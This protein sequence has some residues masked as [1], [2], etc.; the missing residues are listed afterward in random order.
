MGI[1]IAGDYQFSYLTPLYYSPPIM[2]LFI[3]GP[4]VM[5][6][7]LRRTSAASG[8]GVGG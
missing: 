5:V 4:I 7:D 3:V 6:V 8:R 2:A 1:R